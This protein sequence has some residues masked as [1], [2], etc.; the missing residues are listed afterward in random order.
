MLKKTIQDNIVIAQLS[1]GATNAIT[2]E[3][4]RQLNDI[5][6]DVN[7]TDDLKGIVLTGEG[8]FFSS[9]FSLPT[10]IGFETGDAAVAF[11]EEEEDILLNYFTCQKPVVCALNG[12]SAAMGMILAL[13]SDYRIA[14]SHPKIK[15]GM[16]EIKIGLSLSVAQ[17]AIA[18]F[19]LDSNKRYRD[20]M[21]F[22][23]MMAPQSALEM[24]LVDEVVDSERLIDRAKE[25]ICLWI[26][27]PN[28]PF[29]QLKHQLN[30]TV[31]E[32]I[33]RD[34]DKGEWKALMAETMM[35][36]AVKETLTFV[37]AMME[38]KT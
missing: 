1:D 24:G 30:A 18:R 4:L 31:A 37:Q 25:I 21:Y 38:S 26:D 13:A 19:G 29:I 23:E 7:N 8:R 2:I 10:F 17:S 16:S 6:D 35:N 32:N 11:F 3:M 20:V 9:G 33:R 28:R 22:G 34:L 27:T 15:I 36:K 14:A 12:H 5:I